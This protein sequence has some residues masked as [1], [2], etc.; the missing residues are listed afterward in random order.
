MR[1]TIVESLDFSLS[2]RMTQ[3]EFEA[4][5]HDTSKQINEPISWTE[6]PAHAP[7]VEFRV[8]VE[9]EESY[10]I[11]VKGSYNKL[12]QALTYVLIHRQFGRIYGLD[13]GKDHRNPDGQRVGETHKSRRRLATILPR[14]PHHSQ[15][16]PA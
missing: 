16:H 4:L 6:N 15:R 7:T 12:I 10:P 1:A 8:S 2:I 3:D 13:L 9:S 11:F 14:S 5:L